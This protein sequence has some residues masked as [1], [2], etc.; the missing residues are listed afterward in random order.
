MSQTPSFADAIQEWQQQLDAYARNAARLTGMESERLE[1]EA[2]LQKA[3]EL[4][5]RQQSHVGVRQQTTKEINQLVTSGQELLRRLRSYAKSV[6]GTDNELLV[7]FKVAPRRPRGRR[8]PKPPT[9]PPPEKPA[10]EDAA[11]AQAPAKSF[12]SKTS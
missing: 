3:R 11:P 4:K 6:L 8:K 10:P 12:E 9:T 7:D 2:M 1:L 5:D